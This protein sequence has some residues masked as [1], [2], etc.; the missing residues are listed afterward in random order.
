M[1]IGIV[2]IVSDFYADSISRMLGDM[3]LES[4]RIGKVVTGARDDCSA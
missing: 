2:L 4:W 1:G 3:G